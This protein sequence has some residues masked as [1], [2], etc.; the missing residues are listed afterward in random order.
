MGGLGIPHNPNMG[1]IIGL[2]EEHDV[3]FRSI[4]HGVVFLSIHTAS[5]GIFPNLTRLHS[6]LTKA[7]SPLPYLCSYAVAQIGY[8]ALAKPRWQ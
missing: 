1:V 2:V 4:V 8:S 3:C 6:A 5:K 7:R